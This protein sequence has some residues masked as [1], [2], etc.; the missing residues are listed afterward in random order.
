M[1]KHKFFSIF[2]VDFARYKPMW[3]G[4]ELDVPITDNGIGEGSITTNNQPFLLYRITHQIV[5]ASWDWLT[6]GLEQ[7]GQYTIEFRDEQSNF[8][9]IALPAPTLYGPWDDPK[10][11]AIPLAYSGNRTFKFR[12]INRHARVLTPSADYFKL[13]IVMHGVS[14]WGPL[15]SNE[16]V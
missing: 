16:R 5:G 2:D 12:V 15:Q 8:Q 3:Y 14:D 10:D 9:N 1:D 13:A 7:D 11:F 6:T 4:L